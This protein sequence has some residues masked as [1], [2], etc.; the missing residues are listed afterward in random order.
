[1]V[2]VMPKQAADGDAHRS[3]LLQEAVDGWFVDAGGVYVD[4]TYGRGGH[5]L[6]L[7]QRLASDATLMAVDR[8]PRAIEV[9]NTMAGSWPQMVVEHAD[10]ARIP[11]LVDAHGWRGKISGILLD[12]GVSSPQLDEAER[13]FSF[14]RDGDLD[15]RMNP[16]EGMTAADW[17]ANAS[18]AEI[19]RILRRYGEER[20]AQR[21]AT[22]IDESRQLAPI[23]RTL[24]LAELIAAT[25]PRREP[26]KHPATRS[27]QAIRMVVNQELQQLEAFLGRC[28]D[29]LRPGGRL[30]IISFHSLED[31]MV[32]RFF[33][34]EA[35]ATSVPKGLPIPDS[36][37]PRQLRLCGAAQRAAA[38]EVAANPRSRSAVLRVAEKI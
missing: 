12:L 3:V 11:E 23:D 28:L 15:M 2:Q 31:R 35:S 17:L 19:V 37:L 26:G 29:V 21:I 27:F 25:V 7:L 20:F 36:E 16:S 13:G 5:S 34:A 22:A 4:G 6:A 30:A 33:R 18:R 14:L 24:Q 38:T 32:K 1:M 9:A 10:F 8:D